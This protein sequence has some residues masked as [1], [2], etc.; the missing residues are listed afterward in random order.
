VKSA[1]T[2][3]EQG[4]IQLT[5]ELID[6]ADA[7]IVMEETHRRQINT[8][9]KCNPD[10]IRVLD[11]SDRFYRNDPELVRLLRLKVPPILDRYTLLIGERKRTPQTQRRA[12]AEAQVHP[13]RPSSA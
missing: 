2:T 12:P 4:C 3:A 6:W 5:Q 8:N 13:S 10:K 11:I 9:Y 1:G 7:I